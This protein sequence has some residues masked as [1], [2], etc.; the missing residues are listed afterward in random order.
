[1]TRNRSHRKTLKA[2]VLCLSTDLS[3]RRLAGLVISKKTKAH[4]RNS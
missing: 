3:L 4:K 2:V 1:M